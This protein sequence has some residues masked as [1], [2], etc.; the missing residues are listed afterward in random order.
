[1][2]DEKQI[3][4]EVQAYYGS[5]LKS[6]KDLKTGACRCNMA[7]PKRHL[8]TLKDIHPEVKDKFYGCGS[9]LPPALE[10]CTILDLG[11]G[12]GR[13][14]FL[15]S[16][17]VGEFGSVIG[18]DI[19]KE[20]LAIALQHQAYHAR[21]F[22]YQQ[23]NV[24]FHHGLIEDLA[25]HGLA[26][27]SIDV[28]ISNCVIN[29]TPDKR[30]VFREIIRVL[31]PGG[32]LYF[33]DI[34]ADRRIP[35]ELRDDPVLR[36]E[37]LG[38]AMYMQDF[39][40]LFLTLGIPD[41]RLLAQAAVPIDNEAIQEKIGH[42]NFTSLTVRAFKLDTLEDRCE[43]FGQTAVYHG[44]IE[45]FPDVFPLDGHHLFQVGEPM[46]VCGNTAAMLSETRYAK[47]FTVQGDRSLHGGLFDCGESEMMDCCPQGAEEPA[48]SDPLDDETQAMLADNA[49]AQKLAETTDQVLESVA[50]DTLQ[51]NIG[52]LC[53]LTCKH[54]HLSCSPERQEMM[55][56]K[57]MEKIT[58]LAGSGEFSVVDITG[59]APELHPDFAR[60]VDALHETKVRIIV[61]TNLVA[62]LEPY[63]QGVMEFLSERRVELVASLPCYLEENVDA[64][65]GPDVHR[66]C[67][68]ALLRLNELGYGIAEELPLSLVY[69]PGGAFL[70]GAQGELEAA[71]RQELAERYGI[72]FTRLLTITN[73]PL[74]RFLADLQK[75]GQAEQYCQTLTEAFNPATVDGLMCRHQLCIDYDGQLYDCDFNLA[76]NLGID[77]GAPSHLDHYQPSA[78]RRRK[79]VTGS[80]CFGCTAGAGSSCGGVLLKD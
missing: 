57:T 50:L 27:N 12:T 13:D 1:M 55:P 58:K 29:L 2:T 25:T 28:V 77:H 26:D 61:R 23:S 42:I 5:E 14:V 9:P 59:G 74:G 39:R 79:I 36:G 75:Q 72:S 20:Q 19:T 32:E 47:H 41:Y 54:C 24:S 40:R 16:K 62:L 56:W 34:F 38:G 43:N 30:R 22:G 68:T 18:V 37:C 67:I 65:R 70:P 80:H 76:L 64:Q 21:Q 6:S 69:N 53:N 31:K 71:Y 8:E 17:L 3:Q 33:A 73:L 66:R 7:Q 48:E 49:F 11:C 4:S 35:Q 15:A 52:R 46:E 60:F 45:D 10:G 63:R 44:S 78:L 51:V